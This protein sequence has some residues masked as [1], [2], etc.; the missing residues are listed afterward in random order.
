MTEYVAPGVYVE[1]VPFRGHPIEGVPT[2]NAALLGAARKGPKRPRLVT[3]YAEFARVFG[4]SGPLSRAARGFFDNDGERLVVARV[5]RGDYE[6]ALAALAD[7]DVALVAAPGAGAAVQR[8]L[9]DHCESTRNRFAVLDAPR[10][11]GWQ[12]LDPRTALADTSYAACYH[13][14]ILT[15]AGAV[16]P[17]GA[18]C[19]I[20][21]R[22]D[23]AR[24]VWKAPAN[25][26]VAGAT[27]LAAEIG[28]DAQE[29]LSPRGV[30]LI[31]RFPERGIRLWG[32]RT[33][34]SD[35]EWKY[36]NVRRLFIFIEESIVRGTQWAVF[37]PND[38]PLWA[39]LRLSIENFL[40]GV[41]RSGALAG[42]TAR[43]ACFVRCDRTTMTQADIDNGVLI[44]EIGVAP[45]RPAEFV[46]VRIMLRAAGAQ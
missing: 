34:S 3:S 4:E 37:E 24:G 25:E 22:S 35:P 14:W 17:S 45:V 27:G 46:I 2:S 41:W 8:T 31:R 12:T 36:V 28:D 18:V 33:L 7:R 10:D 21:A 39:Q 15:A 6:S 29:V 32:A 16:P 38:E 42:M 44:V 9:I 26:P 20:Y 23:I 40:Y 19:G 5:V 1:E 13:P 43:E 30:N 11:A